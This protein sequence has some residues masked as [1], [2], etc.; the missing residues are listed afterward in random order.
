MPE[1]DDHNICLWHLLDSCSQRAGVFTS[2][3]LVESIAC[4]YMMRFSS[5]R[6]RAYHRILADRTRT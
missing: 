2:R 6:E 5:W 1:I 4:V 3:L